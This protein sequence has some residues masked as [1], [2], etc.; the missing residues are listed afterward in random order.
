MPVGAPTPVS[1][2][3]EGRRVG[4][5]HVGPKKDRRQGRRDSACM[6]SGERSASAGRPD[7]PGDPCGGATRRAAALADRAG[8]MSLDGIS[9]PA[10]GGIL[11]AVVVAERPQGADDP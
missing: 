4:P 2:T 5:L 9:A 1:E 6:G 8:A 7:R 3:D 10:D 11:V